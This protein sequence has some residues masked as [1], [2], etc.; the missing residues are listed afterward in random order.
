VCKERFTTYERYC[1]TPLMVVKKDNR[2]EP[3]DRSKILKGI[4]RA[5]NKRGIDAKLIDAMVD[6]IEK[7]V[8]KVSNSEVK[9]D[10]VGKKVMYQ[11][12]LLDKVAYVRFASV[13]KEFDRPDSFI[14][15]AR[16]AKAEGETKPALTVSANP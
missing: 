8:R 16:K 7:E 10:V 15:E 1:E 11:L 13:Y 3:F 9:S 5:C 2:R 4:S 14:E 12:W 6:E